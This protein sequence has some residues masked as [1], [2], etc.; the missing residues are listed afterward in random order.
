MLK[1]TITYTD[2]NGEERTEDFYFNLTKADLIKKEMMTK[3]GYRERLESVG[4]SNNG[5]LIMSVF[6]ELI[7][8]SYGIKSEDGKHF[9]KSPEIAQDFM[10]SA[11]YDTFFMKLVTDADEAIAFTRGIMPPD[12]VEAALKDV[13]TL[14]SANGEK[15]VSD[16]ARERSQA[17]LQGHNSPQQTASS[18]SF[19]S[20]P[21]LPPEAPA[22]ESTNPQ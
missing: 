15:S 2:F 18:G 13:E 11:A 22:S 1:K 14:Q 7:Q 8:D 21:D 4:K 12:L 5:A 16:L 3:G 17:Q 9:A 10:Q 6:T 20:V 19:S